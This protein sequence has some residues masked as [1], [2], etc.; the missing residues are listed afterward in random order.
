[1]VNG[2]HSSEC[3]LT[4]KALRKRAEMRRVRTTSK[5]DDVF[6]LHDHFVERC[7]DKTAE[8]EYHDCLKR[9][10]MIYH[11]IL[12]HYLIERP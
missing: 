3:G 12:E 2:V 4:P 10:R 9:I 7:K 5:C 11:Y 6:V 8:E 1:M